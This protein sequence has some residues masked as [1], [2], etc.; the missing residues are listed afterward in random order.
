[1][2]K[3]IQSQEYKQRMKD[4]KD[5]QEE[6][7]QAR[8]GDWTQAVDDASSFSVTATEAVQTSVTS[9]TD[10]IVEQQKEEIIKE[11]EDVKQSLS[12]IIRDEAREL[13]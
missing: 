5:S 1:M 6:Q 11:I 13:G 4:F 9:A 10:S 7:E 12:V 2:E 3:F 8:K